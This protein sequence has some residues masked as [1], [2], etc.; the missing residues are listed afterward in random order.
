MSTS[1]RTWKSMRSAPHRV[2]HE[3]V[4]TTVTG[5]VGRGLGVQDQLGLDRR[6]DV[7]LVVRVAGEVEL[8]VSS[9]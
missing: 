8:A 1:I 9:S 4:L 6:G 3:A 5:A 2:E 7:V